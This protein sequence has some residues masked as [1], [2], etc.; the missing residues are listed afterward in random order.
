MCQ[1]LRGIDVSFHQFLDR[2][3][4]EVP[5]PS[6]TI[7]NIPSTIQNE[8]R[9]ATNKIFKLQGGQTYLTIFFKDNFL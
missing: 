8:P 3:W 5:S 1:L 6:L 7:N 2:S 9:E 4:T